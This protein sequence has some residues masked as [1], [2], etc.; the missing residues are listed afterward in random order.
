MAEPAASGKMSPW[1]MFGLVIAVLILGTIAFRMGAGE[2]AG[3]VQTLYSAREAIRWLLFIILMAA[4]VT[5]IISWIFKK[6]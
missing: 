6:D 3:G 2:F 4:I 5:G 1:A